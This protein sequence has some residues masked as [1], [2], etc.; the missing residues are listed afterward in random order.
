MSTQT[1]FDKFAASALNTVFIHKANME[2][3]NARDLSKYDKFK[4]TCP[5]LEDF[6]I[7]EISVGGDKPGK[8]VLY[9]CE[10]NN[11][12]FAVVVSKPDDGK[13]EAAV[14]VDELGFT[15]HEK[16]DDLVI[17]FIDEV[18]GDERPVFMVCSEMIFHVVKNAFHLFEH[19]QPYLECY[20]AVN[21]KI[22]SAKTPREMQL[23]TSDKSI[24]AQFF[25]G[26]KWAAKC[27][28]NMFISMFTAAAHSE[29]FY[30]K[31]AMVAG[32]LKSHGVD[33]DS[34]VR[35]VECRDVA[36]KTWG[37]GAKSTDLLED[38]KAG[39]SSAP[40]AFIDA[41]IAEA[42]ALNNFGVA[43]TAFLALVGETKDFSEFARQAEL[44][45]IR[46]EVEGDAPDSPTS[47]KRKLDDVDG[48]NEPPAL[49][50]AM[51][52]APARTFS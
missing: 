17:P 27:P 49:G 30:G 20:K 35:V 8:L 19:G 28:A 46:F 44:H 48:L 18:T 40:A 33:L 23:A 39:K 29:S 47:P 5:K 2:T 10:R 1:Q 6:T 22:F 26:E 41:T 14:L 12:T 24:P 9:V 36:D 15:N 32:L 11:K 43:A 31:F 21:D 38:F 42:K 45:T 34:D 52:E 13:P 16:H 7:N 4:P 50:R 25:L 3:L 37:I 51:S